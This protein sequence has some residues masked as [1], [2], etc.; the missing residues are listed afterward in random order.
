ME[1]PKIKML[2]IQ[3]L[4]ENKVNKKKKVVFQI[5]K[6]MDNNKNHKNQTLLQKIKINLEDLVEIITV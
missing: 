5:L 3:V 2:Q 1:L 4:V 6:I